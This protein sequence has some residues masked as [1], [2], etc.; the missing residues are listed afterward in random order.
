M[1]DGV[2]VESKQASVVHFT[3]FDEARGF[4][5]CILIDTWSAMVNA[6]IL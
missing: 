2:C 3:S 1:D 4:N 5:T 6:V